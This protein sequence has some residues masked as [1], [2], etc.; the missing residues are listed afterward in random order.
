MS[1]LMPF[2]ENP[3]K[4]SALF[5]VGALILI[6]TWRQAGHFWGAMGSDAALWGLTARDLSSGIPS[7]VPPGYP[8]IVALIQACGIGLVEAGWGL[9]SICGALL[10]VV[11]YWLAQTLGAS[12]LASSLAAFMAVLHPMIFEWSHQIQPDA[13]SAVL[14]AFTALLCQKRER[15]WW[16]A[17]F[18]GLLVLFREHG[19]ALWPALAVLLWRS[20]V[21]LRERLGPLMLLLGLSWLSPLLVGQMPG[22]H[23]FDAPWS[24]RTGGALQA[25][26]STDPSELS[27]L[28]ELPREER[29]AY[30]E[31]VL[32]GQR[33]GQIIWHAKR[34]LNLAWDLWC[35]MAIAVGLAIAALKRNHRAPL[36]TALLLTSALPALLIWSQA[37][38]VALVI[39]VALAIAAACW[40]NHRGAK[41]VLSALVLSLVSVWPQRY[42][43]LW[44]GQQGETLRAKNL[45]ELGQWICNEEP[46]GAFLGGFIQDVGLYCPLR[47]HDPNGSMADWRTYVVSDFP[48]P[49]QEQGTWFNVYGSD[50]PHQIYQLEP[51]QDPRPCASGQIDPKS[52]HLAIDRAFGT[53][54]CSP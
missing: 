40:P 35:I 17:V 45:A 5:F 19:L 51:D 42:E 29:Q 20:G 16:V 21:H 8:A 27:F 24:Q 39:P 53:I 23:P 25:L 7:H 41:W 47:R 15:R 30:S 37:R 2:A 38:H 6:M 1:N 32:N 48:P 31:L 18:G 10:P 4:T 43:R 52:P 3:R 46:Q 34:S 13:I 36:W 9:S 50:G 33:I 54:N 14:I 22:V 49:P 28:R 12:T 44:N 26:I 11:V